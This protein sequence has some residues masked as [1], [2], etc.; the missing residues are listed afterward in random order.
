LDKSIREF[1][2]KKREIQRKSLRLIFFPSF[3]TFKQTILF[4]F[5]SEYKFRKNGKKFPLKHNSGGGGRGREI[6]KPSMISLLDLQLGSS[7]AG[8]TIWEV[9]ARP[10]GSC[11]CGRLRQQDIKFQGQSKLKN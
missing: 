2:E 3:S 4:W 9:K 1:E 5:S 10:S 11:I 6:H 8:L 7:L